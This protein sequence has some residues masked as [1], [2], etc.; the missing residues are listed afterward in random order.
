MSALASLRISTKCHRCELPLLA[1]EWSEC[2]SD[3]TTAHM[4][5][6]PMCGHDFATA[7][8]AAARTMPDDQRVDSVF[9]I[10][11]VA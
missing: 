11:L 4:W 9:V 10:A 5:H 7:D 3:K 2:L 8:R 1:P 6:C